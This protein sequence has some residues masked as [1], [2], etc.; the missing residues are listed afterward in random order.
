MP[1]FQRRRAVAEQEQHKLWRQARMNSNIQQFI[2]KMSELEI[3]DSFNVIERHL[4]GEI[5]VHFPP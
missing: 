3:V 1:W 4:L 2:S 5:Q